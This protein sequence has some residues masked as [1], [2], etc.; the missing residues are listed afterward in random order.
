M[1]IFKYVK[2]YS[3]P[4]GKRWLRVR[5]ASRAERGLVILM[6]PGKLVRILQLASFGGGDFPPPPPSSLPLLRRRCMY[7]NPLVMDSV[8]AGTDVDSSV[9]TPGMKRRRGRDGSGKKLR[10]R[11]WRD[12]VV[13]EV[14]AA[15]GASAD[16]ETTCAGS[17]DTQ[18]RG[19]YGTNG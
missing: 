13:L 15:A 6:S 7:T 11:R 1:Y 9:T 2:K 3:G 19:R 14:L 5:C 17:G 8:T 16:S 12:R 18:V 4:R 10:Y